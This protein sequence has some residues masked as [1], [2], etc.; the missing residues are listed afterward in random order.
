M[1]GLRA[2][3][4]RERTRERSVS[5][6]GGIIEFKSLEV[7]ASSV[8]ILRRESFPDSSTPLA[9]SQVRVAEVSAP[10]RLNE[11]PVAD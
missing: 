8:E 4:A 1:K 6:L 9:T 5:A 2:G 3:F 7:P 10:G 11:H